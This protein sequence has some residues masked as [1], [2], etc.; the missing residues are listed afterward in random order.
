[1]AKEVLLSSIRIEPAVLASA[2]FTFRHPRIGAAAQWLAGE[3]Q[4]A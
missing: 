1:M 2:G 3:L 4:H